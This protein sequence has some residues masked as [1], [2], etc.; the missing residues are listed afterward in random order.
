MCI[1][2]MLANVC[3]KK[4]TI[5]AIVGI[6]NWHTA[7]MCIF[8]FATHWLREWPL[9]L[10]YNEAFSLRP[11]TWLCSFLFPSSSFTT[12][13]KHPPPHPSFSYRRRRPKK[14]VGFPYFA[15][16]FSQK[17]NK[18]PPTTTILKYSYRG[19]ER[20]FLFFFEINSEARAH[21]F[22]SLSAPLI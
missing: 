18:P 8:D 10:Y 19:R 15:I 9:P 4:C 17:L 1:L 11:K 3:A 6:S 12:G 22:L 20:N 21:T 2:K 16:F 14:A 7:Y 13:K 5:F